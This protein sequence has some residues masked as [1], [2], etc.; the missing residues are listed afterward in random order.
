MYILQFDPAQ[1]ALCVG[2][3][4]SQVSVFICCLAI[5]MSRF[6]SFLKKPG[7]RWIGTT[8]ATRSVFQRNDGTGPK[9]ASAEDQY[10]DWWQKVDEAA[11]K[12]K[13]AAM[14]RH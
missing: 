9:P 3:K 11:V 7:V 12:S 8:K 4:L 5:F 1:L 10:A 14:P 6:S 2:E 13:P